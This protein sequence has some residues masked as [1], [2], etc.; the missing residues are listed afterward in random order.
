MKNSSADSS[1]KNPSYFFYYF[2]I[3]ALILLYF[4]VYFFHLFQPTDYDLGWHIRYGSDVLKD[5]VIW[6]TNTYSSEL[7]GYKVINSSWLLDLLRYLLYLHTG[8]V[9]IAVAGGLTVTLTFFLI[10]KAFDFTLWQSVL[11]LPI[12]SVMMYAVNVHSLR[13]QEIS[14]LGTVILIY[15]LRKY[16]ERE[17]EKERKGETE[18]GRKSLFRFFSSSPF[19]LYLTI[20]LFL[21]W[22]NL[23]GQFVMGL[24][25]YG[26][27]VGIQVLRQSITFRH[28]RFKFQTS[29]LKFSILTLIIPSLLSAL[30]TLAN[31]Y[32]IHLYTDE[33]FYHGES[34]AMQFISEWAPISQNSGIVWYFLLAWGLIFIFVIPILLYQNKLIRYLPYLIPSLILYAASYFEGRYIWTMF[35]IS[36]PFLAI[37]LGFLNPKNNKISTIILSILL[38]GM[39]IYL[40]RFE[41]PPRELALINWHS[42]CRLTKCSIAGADFLVQNYQGKKIWTDYNYGGFLIWN[43][44][45]IK[46]S[47]DGRMPLWVDPK[48][49]YSPFLA[50]YYPLETANADP[51]TSKYDVFFVQNY[52]P[53]RKLLDNLV[54]QKKW[55]LVFQ[56]EKASI[57]GREKINL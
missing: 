45:A 34:R 1:P 57:Y 39:G 20:P 46:P 11:T 44:P 17:K 12:L 54:E 38:L 29:Y 27:W 6:R 41:L 37:L 15:L 31:P 10:A 14:F 42:Y 47:M 49:N 53:L 18:I 52:R 16:E 24:A 8:M 5:G 13:G 33:I 32:G 4:Y 23:N 19:L 9:G 51:Q 2:S 7:V 28:D 22:A 55:K 30:I 26:L 36:C 3:F 25:I 21:V 35:L 40:V 43:Y 50:T 56:D 48:T